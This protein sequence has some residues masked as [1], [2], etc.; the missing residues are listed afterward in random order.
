MEPRVATNCCWAFNFMAAKLYE[1]QLDLEDGTPQTWLLSEHFN[2]LVTLMFNTVE[3]PDAAQ[4]NLRLAGYEALMELFRCSPSDCYP[5]VKSSTLRVLQSLQASL[6][7]QARDSEVLRQVGEAQALLCGLLGVLLSRLN[8]ADVQSSADGIA[9]VLVS[10]LGMATASNSKNVLEDCF[11]TVSAFAN[12]MTK[13]MAKYMDALNPIIGAS[14]ADFTDHHVCLAAVGVVSDVVRGLGDLALPYVSAYISALLKALSEPSLDR[15]VKP[16][17]VSCFGDIAAA[18]GA[19]FKPYLQVTLGLLAQAAHIAQLP[20]DAEDYDA[21]DAANELRNSILQT[22]TSCLTPLVGIPADLQLLEPYVP[23]M[24]AF[25]D[26]LLQ[27]PEISEDCVQSA[28]GL[29][30]DLCAAYGRPLAPSIP[31]PLTSRLFQ[32]QPH[33]NA[34]TAELTRYA[35]QQFQ[36][37]RS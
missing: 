1:M 23:P 16:H 25:M 28:L 15:S 30:G 12:V 24:F 34:K 11:S 18:L 2:P 4:H 17:I 20:V 33:N 5:V 26:V 22:Y 19:H 14:L 32:A 3:R 36:K 27:L 31:G 35:L 7:V 9:Q 21:V 6:A 37:I 10:I 13:G 29:F 8:P